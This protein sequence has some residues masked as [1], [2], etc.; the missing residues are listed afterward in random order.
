MVVFGATKA[1]ASG[2]KSYFA[3]SRL[4]RNGDRERGSERWMHNVKMCPCLHE[5]TGLPAYSDSVGTA[6]KC[7]CERSVT[8]TGIL[9]IRKSYC[10]PKTV[11]VAGMSL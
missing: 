4:T 3:L 5:D 6:K 11:T 9:G 8:V 1:V 10:G 7:H 2:N